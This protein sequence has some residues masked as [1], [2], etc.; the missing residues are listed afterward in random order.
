MTF[1]EIVTEISDRT[2]LTSST[3]LARIGRSVNV[4]HKR[5]TSSL[6]V[7][8]G[9]RLPAPVGGT[10]VLGS[11]LVTFTGIE[12]IERV[13]DDS[14]GSVVVLDEVLDSEIRSETPVAGEPTAFS[15]VNMGPSTITIR[16]NAVM[17]D[18]RVLKADGLATASTLSGSLEPQLPTDFHDIIVESV[19]A[20]EL[21]VMEKAE[22][23]AI[24]AQ[25]AKGRL[26]ELRLF[27]AK[28]GGLS[29]L[30]GK[31]PGSSSV[32]SG[33]S[34]SG[35]SQGSTSYT[36]TGQITFDR[37]GTGVAPFAVA[38]DND[39]V[40][41]NLNADMV[42][43]IS[44]DDLVTGPATSTDNAIVRFNGTDGSTMQNSGITI[45]DGASG[46]LNGSNSGDVT[47][48]GS[49]NYITIVGQVI[50]RA[51]IDLSSHVTSRLGFGN[52]VAASAASK[53]VGRRS[54]SA[55]EFEEITLGTG[56][57]MSSTT[58]NVTTTPG[59]SDTQV[60]FNDS[61]AFNGDSGLTFNKTTDALTVGGAVVAGGAVTAGG[62]LI[63][64]GAS[65]GQIVFPA[66][67]NASANANTLDD[68]EEGSWTPT[69]A[70]GAALSFS[71]A[72]GS[73]IKIGQMVTVAAH[74]QWPA[75]ADGS[76][77][78]IGSL[79]FTIQNTTNNMFIGAC[80]TDAGT[81]QAVIGSKNTTTLL[82]FDARFL[83]ATP[84]STMG[85]RFLKFTFT[86]RATA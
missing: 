23:A 71:A 4:H 24:A 85:T 8:V 56:L 13:I 73:Y 42:D 25:T 65:A 68:Y 77:A 86:Y 63:I 18:T 74:I 12:K 43:G 66:S 21:R 57:S 81:V 14:T 84:N 75:T 83:T 27:I 62:Q 45:P 52:F 54:G 33:G 26:S 17:Q 28:S 69:D 51:L 39:G 49:P 38:S 19:L 46:S 35:S 47:L 22:D 30:Q 11:Q 34:S 1:D 20:D 9:R 61:N 78:K 31:T 72:E 16:L 40:V 58:L 55:G 60:Q 76:D 41:T 53:L 79:P 10:C 64:S 36:Q 70:S 29:I 82:L 7:Q 6:G 80:A 15:I 48:A 59:G 3:A 50:T 44:G 37:P 67:Q 2:N 32:I 5:V